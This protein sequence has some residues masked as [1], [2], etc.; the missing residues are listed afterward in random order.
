[1]DETKVE[2]TPIAVNHD[3][4]RQKKIDEEQAKIIK[5]LNYPPGTGPG[6]KLAWDIPKI[7]AFEIET[8]LK[9]LMNELMEPMLYLNKKS[10]ER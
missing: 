5:K 7:Y 1:M 4:E 2:D 9:K 8:R 3:E 6:S 10:T